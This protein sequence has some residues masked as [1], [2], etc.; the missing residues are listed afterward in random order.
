MQGPFYIKACK[1]HVCLVPHPSKLD[2]FFVIPPVWHPSV[3]WPE[4]ITDVKTLDVLDTPNSLNIDAAVQHYRDKAA[5][6]KMNQ[7][8]QTIVNANEKECIICFSDDKEMCVKFT[9][10]HLHWCCMSCG[11]KLKECPQCRFVPMSERKHPL[12]FYN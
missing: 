8:I 7:K 9:C 4:S 12:Q 6:D 2:W 1:T 3:Q 10:H 11:T 5:F